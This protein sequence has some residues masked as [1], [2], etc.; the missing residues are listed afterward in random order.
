MTQVPRYNDM[1]WPTVEAL[2]LLGGSGTIEEVN[3]AV[4]GG[5]H[6][7]E[8]V[9]GVLHGDGPGTEIAYRLGWARTYLKKMALADNSERG[10][11]S[12]T[13]KGRVVSEAEIEPLRQAVLKEKRSR[14]RDR[15][16]SEMEDETE[17]TRDWQDQ[18]LDEVMKLAP[19]AFERLAQRLLREAGFINTQVL[20]R[21]GDQ[22]VDGVG[23]YRLSLISFPVYFQCKRYK[24][25]VGSGA[26]RDFRGAMAGRGDKGLLITTGTFT[27]EAKAEANRDGAP[28]IDLIDGERLTLLLKEYRI[29]LTV[30]TR[31]VEDVTVTKGYFD[32][33]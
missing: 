20:G 19:D 23:V 4:I 2:R 17:E 6:Y 22:G 7:T 9:Q 26:V 24:G 11:W 13:D 28:P 15:K 10:V 1:L 16:E 21:S 8:E 18:L 27:A 25:S 33:F 12:L 29:G 31:V 30:T 14:R 32:G 3:D 5:E